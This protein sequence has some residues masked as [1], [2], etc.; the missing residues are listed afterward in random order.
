MPQQNPNGQRRGRG[1]PLKDLLLLEGPGEVRKTL[2]SPV[3]GF[4]RGGKVRRTGIYKLHKVS[5]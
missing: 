3:P 1:S 4:E 5:V 2:F